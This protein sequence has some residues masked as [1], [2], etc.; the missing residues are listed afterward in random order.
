MVL[1]HA[2]RGKGKGHPSNKALLFIPVNP[3]ISAEFLSGEQRMNEQGLL[4]CWQRT[5]VSLICNSYACET[6]ADW[7]KRFPLTNVPFVLPKSLIYTCIHMDQ[8]FRNPGSY[9]T[10]LF[11]ILPYFRVLPAH[12]FTRNIIGDVCRSLN[13]SSYYDRL[14]PEQK[15]VPYRSIERMKAENSMWVSVGRRSVS[16]GTRGLSKQ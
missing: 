12:T 5:T 9:K 1:F 7:L 11:P 15:H 13:L 16:L 2:G 3:E 10:R 6:E 14:S 4:I 8:K